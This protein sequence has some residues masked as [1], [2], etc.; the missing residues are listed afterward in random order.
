MNLL[1]WSTERDTSDVTTRHPRWHEC[2]REKAHEEENPPL[3]R[4]GDGP[5]SLA[6]VLRL[7]PG[8]DLEALEGHEFIMWVPDP[9]SVAVI[10]AITVWAVLCPQ[11]SRA[12]HSDLCSRPRGGP[13]WAAAE[14][15]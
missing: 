2:R 10:G 6:M 4:T 5:R 3:P 14:G 13:G 11:L 8:D 9:A 1:V 15:R 12:A 7:L